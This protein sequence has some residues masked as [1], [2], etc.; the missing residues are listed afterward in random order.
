MEKKL[1]TVVE[2]LSNQMLKQRMD[3]NG[4][5]QEMDVYHN[6]LDIMSRSIKEQL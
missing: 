6:T 4:F 3:V 2:Q 5:K 1:N